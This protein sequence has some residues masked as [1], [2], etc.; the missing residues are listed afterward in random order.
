MRT[1]EAEVAG[2]EG[3]S[4]WFAREEYFGRLRRVQ[5]EMRARGFEALLAFQPESVTWLTGFFTR[6]YSTFQFA[7]VPAEGEPSVFCRDVARYYLD[8]TCVFPDHGVWADGEDRFAAAASFLGQRLGSARRVGVEL[9]AWQMTAKRYLSLQAALPDLQLVDAGGLLAR[10]RLVKSPAEIA[11]QRQ[12]ARAAE[13]GM[14][15]AWTR[16]A[17]E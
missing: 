9:D 5:E 10:L 17:P 16:R 6:G 2:A 15:A 12:A 7:Y 8:R 4:P 3:A 11:L 1:G 14:Q 13:A